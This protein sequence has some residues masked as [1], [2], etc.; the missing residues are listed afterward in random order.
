MATRNIILA[1]TGSI[2]A[3]KSAYLTRLLVKKGYDVQILMTP[4][5]KAFVSPTT[6]ATLSKHPVQWDII[7]G[8]QWNSH[9][10]LGLWADA[11]L[12]APCTAN[13]LAKCANGLADSLVVATYLSARC[14]VFIAPAM[15]LDMW[16]HGST[17]DNLDIVASRGDHVIPVGTGELA[18][19]LVGDGRMAE[20][21]EI[22]EF[23]DSHLESSGVFS[24]K[25]VMITAGPTHEHFD[26]VRFIGN[27]ST[28][29]MGI[30]IADRL[31]ALGADVTLI[32]GPGSKLPQNEMDVVRV[33]T[34]E[35]MRDEAVKA[36][37]GADIAV[38]SA[39][40]SDFRPAEVHDR[41]IKKG[42]GPMTVTLERTPD[43]AAE[44]AELKTDNQI[45]VGFA[46]ETDNEEANA[47]NKLE[48]KKFDLIVL[49]SLSDPGAGFGEATN[50]IT[51]MYPDRSR[52]EFELKPKPEVA[53]DIVSALR[54]IMNQD[55]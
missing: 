39:A 40:V 41:K 12:I 51:L 13:T 20:P 27:P 48:K 26:P 16:E 15:D 29:T 54:A 21:E 45:V 34:A 11:M 50:K 31:S 23:L 24:G 38:L 18:S 37:D 10:E 55:I 6:F 3:Y 32:L 33:T 7:E 43:I 22:I 42:P 2:A 52:Q 8:D 4:A 44:L 19:G 46:L 49:N 9:V 36:F 5:A 25:K 28:G 35:Q 17:K 30:A 53:R 1:V 47:Y 14:P